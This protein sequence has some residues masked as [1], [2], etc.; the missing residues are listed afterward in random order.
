MNCSIAGKSIAVHTSSKR[1]STCEILPNGEYVVL[2]LENEPNLV[3]LELKNS[4]NIETA[5]AATAAGTAATTNEC[6]SNGENEV[7]GDGE[8]SGKTFI[9]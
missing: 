6:V 8:N 3:T 4:G 9:L 7:Y 1:I 5:A 2:A